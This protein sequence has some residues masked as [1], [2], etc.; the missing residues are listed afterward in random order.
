MPKARSPRFTGLIRRSSTKRSGDTGSASTASR[1]P[2]TAIVPM[3]ARVGEQ[4]EGQAA[5]GGE[6]RLQEDDA[7]AVPAAEGADAVEEQHPEDHPHEVV[8]RHDQHLHGEGAP[9]WRP[10]RRRRCGSS[11][12]APS[13]ADHLESSLAGPER[14]RRADR[15]D[16]D[17]DELLEQQRTAPRSP[18]RGAPARRPWPGTAGTSRTAASPSGS[19]SSGMII[20]PRMNTA[21][22]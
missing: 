11:P 18:P 10:P 2:P 22:M 17:P 20:P 9:A 7:V 1:S 16:T 13:S 12:R 3:R 15:E 14:Q 21:F 6:H 4:A 19:S 5:G 8:D